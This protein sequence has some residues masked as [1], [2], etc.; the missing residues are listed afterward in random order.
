MGTAI[1]ANVFQVH[2]AQHPPS[3]EAV[4][5]IA[6]FVCPLENSEPPTTKLEH[7]GHE[8]KFFQAPVFV[9]GC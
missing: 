1:A 2:C 3:A 9:Q 5:R 4:G 8:R 6:G 7:F